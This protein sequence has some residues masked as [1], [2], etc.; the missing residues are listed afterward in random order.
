MGAVRESPHIDLSAGDGAG[1]DVRGWREG[2]AGWREGAARLE[3]GGS[4][5]DDPGTA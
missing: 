3:R 4:S 5:Q 2:A 1:Q